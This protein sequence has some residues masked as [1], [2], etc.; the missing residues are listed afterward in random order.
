M[1][2]TN[3]LLGLIFFLYSAASAF[4]ADELVIHVFKD[5]AAGSG[6]T[7]ALDGETEASTG[8][9]GAAWFDMVPGTHSL[10]ILEN[11][12][13]LHS[14]RFN[15]AQGQYTDIIV[16][17]G[18]GDPEVSIE[19]YYATE[20]AADR[21]EAPI[22][23][24]E[25]RV[26]SF[27]TPVAGAEIT[28]AGEDVQVWTDEG[29]RYRLEL[30]RG[31]YNL[32]ITH[33]EYRSRFIRAMRLVA[34]V[35]RSADFGLT[36]DAAGVMEEV[37][38]VGAYRPEGM[39]L[40]ERDTTNVVDT[41]G[42][43]D[44][45]R[46]GDTDV[47]AAVIRL[48]SVTVQDG[49]FV[50]IRGLG[51]R[52]VTTTLNGATLP[53][54]DPS[55]RT[56]P[57]DLFP[58]NI[59]SQLDVKKTFI[60]PMP[61]ESTGGNLVINTRTFPDERSGKISISSDATAGV[62][63]RDVFNDPS[64]GGWDWVGWD[65]G[66]REEPIAVTAIAEALSLGT[67]TDTNNGATFEINDTVEREL[68]RLGAILLSENLDLDKATAYPDVSVGANYGDLFAIGPADL[69]IFAAVNY[70]NGW[71]QKDDGT[72]NSYSPGQTSAE[73]GAPADI[74]KFQEYAN[75]IDISGLFSVGLTIG[76]HT[77]EANSIL[78][79]ATQSKVRRTVG[80]EGDEFNST[81]RHT[82]DWVERQFLSQQL[83]GS[84]FLNEAGTLQFDWQGTLSQAKRIAPDRR[85][86]R[87]DADST[88]TA[89]QSL[90]DDFDLEDQNDE[91]PVALNGF[92]L[93]ANQLL[94]RYDDLT[95]DNVDMSG[96]LSYEFIS[97]GGTEFNVE[98]GFSVIHRERDSDSSSYGFNIEQALVD[99]VR[100]PNAL[101]SDVIREDA[102]TGSNNTGFSFADKTL[103]S[104]S[105]EAELDLNS[106]YLSGDYLF[107]ADYQLIAG[108]RFEDYQQ[109]TDTFSLAGAQEAV[110]S[111]IDEAATLPSLGFNWF[112]RDD[113][114]FRFAIYKTVSRP[115]FK[116][117][118]NAT[119]YDTEFDFRVRGNPNLD[120]SE[121]TNYDARW[122][123]YFADRQSINLAVFYKELESPIE[124]V[125]QPAS[126]T[127][128]NSRTYRNAES[129]ELYGVEVE[130]RKDF[131]LSDDLSQ[132]IFVFVN[133]GV[134]ESEV[135]H[136]DGEKRKLQGQPDYTFNMVL[137][138]DDLVRDQ[139]L[140]V[141]LNQNGKSIKD[142]G[143]S[144]RPDV[145]EEPRLDLKV[146]YKYQFADDFL[147]KASAENLLN[148]KV[149]FTQGGEVFQSYKEGIQFKLGI[150]WSF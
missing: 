101:V 102:I 98:V 120:I 14:F 140:T 88:L 37:V 118:S 63:G 144:G 96:A 77:F 116:E 61:G 47:A 66:E 12:N 135:S 136:A 128:G 115:D 60:S 8:V 4:A 43:E 119:F 33:P 1:K 148:E 83:R 34:N 132:S 53:S 7:V 55:R 52:Y 70:K 2:I 123:W 137:G 25:G 32:E 22:A 27:G 143:I 113:H 104:D 127:A 48:P 129:G 133:A 15:Y 6:L 36:Q 126:G 76:D 84:H 74:L 138:Y 72:S 149:E 91:Q 28:V 64:D 85:E 122:E 117:T 111:N 51:G 134:I 86:V 38:V 30:P 141:L 121:V 42:I 78:S 58:S 31:A 139:E 131:A 9:D 50:F 108:I 3:Y 93:E 19:S 67:V 114:Q 82:I 90:L 109:T 130:V 147:L 35:A 11:G 80:Q 41:L 73:V 56:V 5:G 54:T 29:G 65:A 105:Y 150:D 142:L 68:R 18:A 125:V 100:A 81:L 40:V 107:N 10:Q 146:N 44:L 45:A 79:R 75:D 26:T 13:P 21:A 89:P 92:L 17:L 124:R 20:T 145:I 110:T 112:Y 62:T 23:V 16:V 97:D 99:K 46:F 95:D 106:I 71:S 57:L 39:E 87:F 94:R 69:G 24:L 103:A 49:K 59:V